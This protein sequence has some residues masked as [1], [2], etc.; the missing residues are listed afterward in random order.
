MLTCSLSASLRFD[1][2]H[3]PVADNRNLHLLPLPQSLHP[4]RLLKLFSVKFASLLWAE[5]GLGNFILLSSDRLTVYAENN[6]PFLYVKP[7]L[8]LCELA[9]VSF[10]TSFNLPY[11]ILLI[12]NFP[13]SNAPSNFGPAAF[14]T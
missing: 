14:E 9:K 7:L 3:L 6:D 11:V 4:L 12:G 2:S 8:Q 13:D 10:I 5:V 1:A